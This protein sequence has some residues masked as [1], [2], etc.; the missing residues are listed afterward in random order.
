[1]KRICLVIPSLQPGGMERVMSE[2]SHFFSEKKEIDLHLV[3][4]GKNRDV[5]YSIPKNITIHKPEWEFDNNK[6][7]FNTVKTLYFLRKKIQEIQPDTILSLGEYW[8]SFVLLSLYG[9]DYPIYVSDRCQPDKNLG[10]FHEY[11]RKWLYP[12]AAGVI[13]QTKTAKSIFSEKKLNK[14]I[15]VIGNPIYSIQPPGHKIKKEN[16]ILTV[17]R[18]IESKHHDRLIHIFNSIN[19]GDWKL[20]IVGGNALKQQGRERLNSIIEEYGIED[21]VELTGTV[22]DVEKY[23]NISKIFA[24]TSSSEGFPNV[25]GEAMSAG[26]P[27]IAYDCIAGP[28]DLIDDNQNGFLIPLFNEKEFAEKLKKLIHNDELRK[29]MGRES[30]QKIEANSLE[31]IGEKY[32]LFIVNDYENPSN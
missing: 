28:S 26:L 6:R 4:Y 19:P 8:N 3:M 15:K 30:R 22:S 12:K 31:V 18:L 16:I 13:A 9:L 20:V 2:L 5:F 24:F 14:N 32:Y 10:F 25:I 21:S 17:G 7:A 27:V 11:L 1:M 29:S 23:Y